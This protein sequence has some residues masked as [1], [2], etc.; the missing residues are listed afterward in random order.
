MKQFIDLS[1]IWSVGQCSH[2]ISCL[3]ACLHKNVLSEWFIIE[4][5]I[6]Y[7]TCL[8]YYYILATSFYGSELIG[9]KLAIFYLNKEWLHAFKPNRNFWTIILPCCCCC[10]CC[11]MNHTLTLLSVLL[12]LAPLLPSL[13]LPLPLP[14]PM[15]MPSVILAPKS[16]FAIWF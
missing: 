4:W 11:L 5:I 13:P 14:M 2:S 12:L 15:P 9:Y 8:L 3:L 6:H 1:I 16:S 10:Y 7:S